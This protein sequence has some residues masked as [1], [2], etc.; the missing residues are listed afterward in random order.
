[1]YTVKK[2]ISI[3]HLNIRSLSK[4]FDELIVADYITKHDILCLSETWLNASH[5][6]STFALPNHRFIRKDRSNNKTRGG[7]LAIYLSKSIQYDILTV[8]D[9]EVVESLAIK[10]HLDGGSVDLVLVYCPPGEVRLVA[11]YIEALF[12]TTRVGTRSTVILGDFNINWLKPSTLK[13]QLKDLM[14]LNSFTQLIKQP[15][16]QIDEHSGTIID[17]LFSNSGLIKKSQVTVCDISDH[18]LISCKLTIETKPNIKKRIINVI[19]LNLTRL[20]FLT[21]LNI[22]VSIRLRNILVLI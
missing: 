12:N 22:L 9:S 18:N 1:M 8:P 14:S 15:T 21:M 17:L 4:H 2:L 16:R 13:T 5:H 20:N 3:S 10:I 11:P 19:F 7:G 6:N